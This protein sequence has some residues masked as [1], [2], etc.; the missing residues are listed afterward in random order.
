[1]ATRAKLSTL[2][3]MDRHKCSWSSWTTASGVTPQPGISI[4]STDPTTE[5][6]EGEESVV[7]LGHSHPKCS[8]CVEILAEM[9]SLGDHL[10]H[11]REEKRLAEALCEQV[12]EKYNRL[13][14]ALSALVMQ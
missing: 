14:R 2:T 5:P 9:E 7:L 4:V 13:R 3:P 10:S 1:M 8:G 6:V 11:A 12:E